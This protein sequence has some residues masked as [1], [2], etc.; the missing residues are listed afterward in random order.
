MRPSFTGGET[1]AR[2]HRVRPGSLTH[3]PFSELLISSR[4]ACDTES[5]VCLGTPGQQEGPEGKAMKK[6]LEG[7]EARRAGWRAGTG[8]AHRF[9][10]PGFLLPLLLQ[11]R[12]RGRGLSLSGQGGDPYKQTPHP[13]H[14][15]LSLGLPCASV[16]SAK[17]LVCGGRGKVHKQY[18]IRETTGAPQM[19]NPE[20]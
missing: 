11:P 20:D 5:A 19:W 4:V 3:N 7:R 12:P 16:V 13:L 6:L 18:F 8:S 17:G 14:P 15:P 9:L 2:G 1:E 10:T